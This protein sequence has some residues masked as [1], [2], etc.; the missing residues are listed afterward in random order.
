M[1][2][3]KGPIKELSLAGKGL[4]ELP[5][6][7]AKRC[8][9][10]LIKL[11]LT[12]NSI[13]S[14]RNFEGLV[15]LETL[16]LDKNGIQGLTNFPRMESVTTLWLNNNNLTDMSSAVDSIKDAFPNLTYLSML[17]NP[18]TP[19]IYLDDS[20]AEAY[21]RYRY[22]I[23]SRCPKLA[24]LD[25]TPIDNAEKKE[26]EAKGSF[27]KVAKPKGVSSGS[28]QQEQNFGQKQYAA[29]VSTTPPKVATFL[30][31]G[32]PRYDGTNSEGN[33]FIVNDDL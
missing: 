33:R 30:A 11:D 23:I 1:S 3:K 4:D 18:C 12:D 21:Q 6:E 17:M 20:A 2:K 25:S 13:T 10:T 19:N 15:K 16:I 8:G 24:F 22:F 29:A 9:D 7:V 32:K 27:L 31:K 14:G 26:A 5:A 28:R